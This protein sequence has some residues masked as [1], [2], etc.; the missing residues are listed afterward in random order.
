[1]SLDVLTSFEWSFAELLSN[2]A[3]S[4]L[5]LASKLHARY[6]AYENHICFCKRP[7]LCLAERRLRMIE[8]FIGTGVS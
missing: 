1:M 5:A 2:P 8:G 7:G 4:E 3:D 6:F